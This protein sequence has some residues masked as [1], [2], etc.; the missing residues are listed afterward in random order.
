M[1]KLKSKSYAGDK[2]ISG[3]SISFPVV[4]NI[5]P[6][7]DAFLYDELTYEVIPRIL[8]N[9]NTIPELIN[10][11]W[12]TNKDLIVCIL[13]KMWENKQDSTNISLIFDIATKKLK[14]NLR[15]KDTDKEND[16]VDDVLDSVESTESENVDPEYNEYLHALRDC[17]RKNSDFKPF[18]KCMN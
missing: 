3:I 14:E 11:I 15:P 12:K 10:E 16:K 8:T 7:S 6:E 13:A 18:G 4:V 9:K 5:N 2:S 1:L 17:E